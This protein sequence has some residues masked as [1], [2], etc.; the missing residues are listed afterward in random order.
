MTDNK[1]VNNYVFGRVLFQCICCG[2]QIYL[3]KRIIE[4]SPY[5][6]GICL[7]CNK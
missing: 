3:D 5:S 7:S 1:P 6:K 2:K 4:I